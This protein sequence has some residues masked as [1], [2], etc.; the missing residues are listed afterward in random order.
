MDRPVDK[1]RGL[2]PKGRIWLAAVIA[3]LL[4]LAV[5]YP[6]IRRWAQSETSIAIS[7]V[8][9]ATVTRGDLVRDVSVEGRSLPVGFHRSRALGILWP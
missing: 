9:I 4:V 1:V 2:S 3:L 7:R 6:S 8:R 5:L